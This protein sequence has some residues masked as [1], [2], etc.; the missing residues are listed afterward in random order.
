MDDANSSELTASP[1]VYTV[2]YLEPIHGRHIEMDYSGQLIVGR[3][4][5]KQRIGSGGMADVYRAR[6]ERLCC[7]VAVKLLKPRLASEESCARMF[8]EA[9]ASAAIDHPHILRITDVGRFGPSI[10]LAMDLLTGASLETVLRGC[11]GQRL[12][13]RRTIDLFL[14]VFAAFQAAHD[15]GFIHRD[16]KPDNLFLHCRGAAERLIVLDLGIVKHMPAGPQGSGLPATATGYVLGTPA[17]MSPEQASGVPLGPGTDIY[18]LGVTLYR[19]ISGRL[20]F[21][22]V[23]GEPHVVLARHLHEAPPPLFEPGMAPADL[24]PGLEEVILRALAKRPERRQ[25]SMSEFAIELA[26]C[27]QPA[28]FAMTASAVTPVVTPG[29]E[30]RASSATRP[31]DRTPSR[32]TRLQALGPPLVL[33]AIAGALFAWPSPPAEGAAPT[34]LGDDVPATACTPSHRV[35][36]L[37]LSSRP[38][39]PG[40]VPESAAQPLASRDATPATRDTRALH[41]VLDQASAPIER[42][43]HAYGDADAPSLAVALVITPAGTVASARVLDPDASLLPSCVQDAVRLLHFGPGAATRIRHTF[44]LR[45]GGAP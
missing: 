43:V 39:P 3:Y 2:G 27:L 15:A 37:A 31:I 38:A 20:P 21:A 8:Q 11:P 28:S 4:N 17:Y 32:N 6:D 34:R 16:I 9:R 22:S 33:A 42:C 19:A 7:D 26:A 29:A 40:V 5:I 10:Y 13:W 25:A 24:P 36:P 41:K 14:P 12:P 30:P 1:E 35:V 23:A 18:S 44:R 45:R